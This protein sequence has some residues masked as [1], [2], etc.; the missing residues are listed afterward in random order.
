M[1]IGD[2]RVVLALPALGALAGLA[3]W[4]AATHRDARIAGRVLVCNAP[5]NCLTRK[6]TV[7]AENARGRTV[8]RTRTKGHGNRY[9]LRV[10][11]GSYELLA[12]SSGLRCEASARAR[13][14]HTT[15]QD[16]TCPVP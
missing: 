3:G 2:L 11:P 12:V 7:S 15:H 1:R 14:H 4:Q 8:A 9:S 16:I 5:G 13:A 6:F 10:P